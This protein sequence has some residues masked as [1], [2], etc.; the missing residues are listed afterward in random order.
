[1]QRAS[2]TGLARQW[3]RTDGSVGDQAQIPDPPLRIRLGPRLVLKPVVFGIT[4][5]PSGNQD[6]VLSRWIML[7]LGG[8][9]RVRKDVDR[10]HYSDDPQKVR[11]RQM[12]EL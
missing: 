7:P 5:T 12:R 6:S 8:S 11:Y 9:G 4:E 3:K 10:Q 1:M 2:V